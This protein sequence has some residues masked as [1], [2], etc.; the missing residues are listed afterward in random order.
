MKVSIKKYI[1]LVLAVLFFVFSFFIFLRANSNL[2]AK[3]EDL[4]YLNWELREEITGKLSFNLAQKQL[5]VG[6]SEKYRLL[7]SE[8]NAWLFKLHEFPTSFYC[9]IEESVSRWGRL[10]GLNIP[11][12]HRIVLPINGKMIQG[13]IQRIIPD[14]KTLHG[15][16]ISE[17]TTFQISELLEQQVLDYFV[18]N[19]GSSGDNFLLSIKTGEIYGIDKDSSFDIDEKSMRQKDTLRRFTGDGIYL[20]IW[21]AYSAKRLDVDIYS[22]LGLIDLMNEVSDKAVFKIFSPI[23]NESEKVTFSSL[24][25]LLDKRKRMFEEFSGFYKVLFQKREEI[26]KRFGRNELNKYK[27]QVIKRLEREVI[28]NKSLLNKL[29]MGGVKEQEDIKVVSSKNAWLLIE[30]KIIN[31]YCEDV[32]FGKQNYDEAIRSLKALRNIPEST[33]EKLAITI[34]ILRVKELFLIGNYNFADPFMLAKLRVTFHPD[35]INPDA[36]KDRYLTVAGKD[37]YQ[38]IEDEFYYAMTL[39]FHLQG[40]HNKAYYY[41][42][43]VQ[44]KGFNLEGILEKMP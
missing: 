2:T 6:T 19:Y 25:D 44:E 9:K 41:A 8:N 31:P 33:A 23:L 36:L 4:A 26:F 32:T 35:L 21:D 37:I 3:I 12:V 29:T 39:I 17:L 20:N 7:D 14:V 10:C 18:D 40:Q 16:D 11:Y 28:D 30:D 38:D 24:D 22:A 43:K 1:L 34:Y 5:L 15:F 27:K 13:T 42:L